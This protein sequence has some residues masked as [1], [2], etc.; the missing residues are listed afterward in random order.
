[1][2]IFL[3]KI[4]LNLPLA[5]K[6][7][8]DPNVDVDVEALLVLIGS[9]LKLACSFV[10]FCVCENVLVPDVWMELVTGVDEKVEPETALDAVVCPNPVVKLVVVLMIKVEFTILH[11]LLEQQNKPWYCPSMILPVWVHCAVQPR[12]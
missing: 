11:K 7:V 4:Y 3:T 2:F 6:L 10:L 1:M 12:W 5:W 8:I 9:V